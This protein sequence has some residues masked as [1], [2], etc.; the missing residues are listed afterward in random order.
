MALIHTA[1]YFW[2][3]STGE[4]TWTNPLEPST[5]ASEPNS[6]LPSEAP[7]LPA[8]PVPVPTTG[9]LGPFRPGGAPPDIDPD[10]AYLLPPEARGGTRGAGPSSMGGAGGQTAQFN[11]RTGR[12]T[13]A[14]YKFTVDH[15][16]EYNRMKRMNSQYFDQEAWERERAAEAIKRQRDEA[17]GL[18]SKPQITKKDMVSSVA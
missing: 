18:A 1:W 15:L 11:A 8:G 12:F 4:V 6:P 13:A 9:R 7:P 17:Q 14:D 10:L 3:T 16:D 5:S 2:N